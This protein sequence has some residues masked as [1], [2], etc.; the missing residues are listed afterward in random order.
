MKRSTKIKGATAVPFVEDSEDADFLKEM[1]LM[2]LTQKSWENTVAI[3]TLLDHLLIHH[4]RH[5][6]KELRE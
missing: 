5:V 4:T 2:W 3:H 6:K 1:Y